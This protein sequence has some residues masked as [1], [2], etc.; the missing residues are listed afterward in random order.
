M[1]PGSK[2]DLDTV[3]RRCNY[4][5]P[6]FGD[7]HPNSTVGL[8]PPG[9][10]RLDDGGHYHPSKAQLALWKAYTEYWRFVENL[11][12]ELQAKCYAVFGGDGTDDNRHSK[13]QLATVNEAVMVDVSSAS[14]EPCLDVSDKFFYIRGT[15]AHTRGSGALEELTAHRIG[16]VE[17][18]LTGND[19]WW[20]LSLE[21]NG[22]RMFFAHHPYSASWR[23][24]TRPG[25]AARTA[26]MIE[27][28]YLSNGEKPP[29][30][31]AFGHVHYYSH[32][33]DEKR[34]Q[35]F[36]NYSWSLTTAFGHRIGA[37][38]RVQPVGGLVFVVLANGD[39]YH[40]R[41]ERKPR[42]REPWTDPNQTAN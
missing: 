1:R 42:R 36:F 20:E 7:T 30:L 40:R 10:I 32:S 21:L 39:W 31:A 25:G 18:N 23:P 14:F 38:G 37:S 27:H 15:E 26:A 35:V 8:C 4:V 17:D 33:G 9:G 3:H 19:S 11:K 29:D 16:A 2:S 28:D 22:V 5:V 41:F 12:D 13:Y 6:F 34:P 24:W